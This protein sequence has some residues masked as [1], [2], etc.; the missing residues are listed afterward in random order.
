MRTLSPTRAYDKIHVSM[1]IIELSTTS[2]AYR[3]LF[4][5]CRSTYACDQYQVP[6]DD[7]VRKRILFKNSSVHIE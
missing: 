2:R 4:V 5:T 1:N 7:D 6:T 3:H